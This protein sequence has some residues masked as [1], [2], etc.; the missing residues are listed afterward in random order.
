MLC[1]TVPP[2]ISK[3]RESL[4][5]G[6]LRRK[7]CGPKYQVTPSYFSFAFWVLTDKLKD[8]SSRPSKDE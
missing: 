3:V 8:G 6:V 1:Q 2:E 7:I 5:L 4:G